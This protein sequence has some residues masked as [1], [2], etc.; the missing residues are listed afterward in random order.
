ML[1]QTSPEIPI[2][3]RLPIEIASGEGCSVTDSNGKTYLDLYGGHAVAA[4]GYNHPALT[5]SIADQTAKLIIQS[6]AV[7]VAIR[8]EAIALLSCLSPIPNTQIFMVN[9]GAEAIENAL[10]IAFLHTK[11]P[12]IA[13][14]KGA[15]HGR[16]A[17]AATITD[18]HDAWYAFPNK[19]FEVDWIDPKNP[20]EL[21]EKITDQT[22]AFIFE[23]IQGV[24]GAIDISP[25]F[26]QRAAKICQE[27]GALIIADEIQSGVGRSGTL[28][29]T[30]QLGIT[31]DITTLAK[32]LAGGLPISAVLA[33]TELCNLPIGTLGTTFG[34]GPVACAAMKTVLETVSKPEFL[35]QVKTNSD[36]LIHKCHEAGIQKITGKGYLLGLH[37]DQPAGPLRQSLLEKGFLTGDAKNPNVIRLL[38]PLI[39]SKTEI[40]SFTQALE[41]T[42]KEHKS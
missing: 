4:L 25:E 15:F 21:D 1:T 29:A 28:F 12:R 2:Y 14:L 22:A 23:P 31:P 33:K 5:K 35:S 3:R 36:Y 17:A 19:P 42:L 38:P 18:Y 9:S 8:N 39:L 30:E 20:A 6:N 34:G 16:S 13:A 32:S 10:R 41:E 11:R 40:D 24:A 37:L 27:R 26:A 7:D